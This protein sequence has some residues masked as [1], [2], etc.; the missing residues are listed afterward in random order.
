MPKVTVLMPVYNGSKYLKAAIDSILSQSFTDFEFLIINDGSTDDSVKIINS[1]HDQRIKLI[2]NKINQGLVA[3]LNQGLKL[4]I[5]E[6]IARMDSDDFS[7]CNRLSQQVR[8]MDKHNDIGVL[9][10][11]VKI[12]KGSD[13]FLGRYFLNHEEIKA[14]LL[15]MLNSPY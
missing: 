13:E 10:S 11:W 5:G 15:F 9:G 4:A 2:D 8:F 3:V 1:Y 14:N 7:T 12:M 6:Y